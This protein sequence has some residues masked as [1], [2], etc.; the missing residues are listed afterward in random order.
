M[1]TAGVD[2]AKSNEALVARKIDG[3]ESENAK[4]NCDVRTFQ[5]ATAS[6][7]EEA[8]SEKLRGL[9]DGTVLRLP[10]DERLEI[11]WTP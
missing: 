2:E 8:S 10:L 6:D 9:C 3:R 4:G 7:D 11:A 1:V 5:A